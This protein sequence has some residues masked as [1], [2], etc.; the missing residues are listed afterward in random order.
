M[1]EQGNERWRQANENRKK[2]QNSSEALRW[3]LK[4]LNEEHQELWLRNQNLLAEKKGLEAKL[5]SLTAAVGNGE[6]SKLQKVKCIQYDLEC[7][8]CDGEFVMIEP[9]ARTLSGS[10]T[11][12]Q[13]GSFDAEAGLNECVLEKWV[14]PGWEDE[15]IKR[16]KFGDADDPAAAAKP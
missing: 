4:V 5:K 7:D 2:M 6:A 12:C 13:C 1:F 16:K 14:P 3:A 10:V 15:I 11:C 9:F 8:N